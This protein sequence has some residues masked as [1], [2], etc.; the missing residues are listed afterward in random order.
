MVKSTKIGFM[1]TPEENRL[2][3][4]ASKFSGFGTKQA[5]MKNFVLSGAVDILNMRA[6][7]L[8]HGSGAR[9]NINAVISGAGESA[10][11]EVSE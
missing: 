6:M 11:K 9:E 1:V 4:M 5:W 7:K 2:V 8:E 10:I 3:L